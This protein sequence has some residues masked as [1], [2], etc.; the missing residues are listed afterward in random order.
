MEF[1]ASREEIMRELS[2]VQ[3]IV[4]R[5][6]TIP[7]LANVLLEAAGNRVE[8]AATDLDVGVRCS[9]PAEV[10]QPGA[11]T[12]SA[13]KVFEIVRAS[14]EPQVHFKELENFW[15]SIVCG[16]SYF[17]MVGLA[18][19]EFP[20]LPDPPPSPLCEFPG[21]RL[22]EMIQQTIFAI[23]GEETRYYLNGALLEI[24]K[25]GFAMVATD[26]HRLAYIATRDPLAGVGASS[27]AIIPRKT[28]S[29][30][31]KM[32]GESEGKVEFAVGDNHLFFRVGE[33]LLISKRVENQFPAWEKVIPRDNDKV[34]GCAREQLAGAIRRVS[35]LANER[36]RAVRLAITP[37]KMEISSQNPELGEARETI[38]IEYR[39]DNMQIGFNGQYLLDFVSAVGA[40]KISIEL[41]DDSSQGLLRKTEEASGQEYRY[42]VMPMRI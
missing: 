6:N 19:A 42:V 5:K 40:E 36:S 12:L 10:K 18:Q 13:K 28:L 17:K 3:G 39:G 34:I 25:G 27:K 22:K 24:D 15:A 16:N 41:K 23:T 33:R 14:A 1:S 32:I 38:D 21:A 2:L 30:L 35:L 26:G 9:F 20:A 11:L 37:G 31:L 4:E 7:V 29:E 8:M